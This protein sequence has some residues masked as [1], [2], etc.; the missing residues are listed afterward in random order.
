M[1]S[2]TVEKAQVRKGTLSGGSLFYVSIWEGSAD[3]SIRPTVSEL[4]AYHGLN[5]LL[6]VLYSHC[7]IDFYHLSLYQ[8]ITIVINC[9]AHSTAA[10]YTKILFCPLSTLNLLQ[11]LHHFNPSWSSEMF[12]FC[13]S[14]PSTCLNIITFVTLSISDLRLLKYQF[15][16]SSWMQPDLVNIYGWFFL[17]KISSICSN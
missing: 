5:L 3:L 10:I 17:F 7:C 6:I 14:C 16:F 13:S 15:C 4:N 1:C 8:I 11:L 12:Q 9:H 2:L